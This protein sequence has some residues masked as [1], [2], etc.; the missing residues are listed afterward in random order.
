MQVVDRG[1]D[2]IGLAEK[3]FRR[4]HARRQ[5]VFHVRQRRF[6]TPGEIDGVGIGLFLDTQHHRRRT[7]ETRI[8]ALH[9]RREI[10]PGDLPQQ[11]GLSVTRPQ[12]EIAQIL[13]L[14]APPQMADQ[15][16]A[17]IDF[18]EAAGTVRRIPAQGAFQLFQA[19]AQFVHAP[20]IR[21]DLILPHRAADRNHLRHAG[22]CQQA[23]PQHPVGVLA[24][25]HGVPLLRRQRNRQHHHFAHHRRHCAHARRD[26]C[27]QFA[28]QPAQA[29]AHH[30]PRPVEIGLPV[31][32]DVDERQ[33]CCR[34]RAHAADTGQTA[35]RGFQR[36]ADQLLHLF[37]RHAARFGHQGH[38]RSVEIGKDIDWQPLCLKGAIQHQDAGGDQHRQAGGQT[39]FQ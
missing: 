36:E 6:Q 17:A 13:Q 39:F 22:H 20:A 18:E 21:L 11:D 15:V 31:E 27:R 32:G 23:R 24:G 16:F 8:A 38:R 2:E 9:R 7:V 29:L 28:G 14:R 34:Y 19:D 33:P 30:L 12:G 4:Q 5:V 37:R 10:D 25:S 1:L 35:E 3:H 26:A